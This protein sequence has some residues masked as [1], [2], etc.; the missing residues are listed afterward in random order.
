MIF[1]NGQHFRIEIGRPILAEFRLALIHE[2]LGG[3]E[4][5]IDKAREEEAKHEGHGVISCIRASEGR[6]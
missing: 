4:V 3:E 1:Q 2:C 5:G 6:Q